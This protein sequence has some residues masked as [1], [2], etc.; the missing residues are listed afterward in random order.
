MNKYAL[1]LFLAIVMIA[2]TISISFSEAL[3][4]ED[5]PE[6][7][8][9]PSHVRVI[10]G[11]NII[12]YARPLYTS[13]DDPDSHLVL[14][15]DSHDGVARL[16]L[17]RTDFKVGCSGTL[18]SDGLHIIT[19]AH[20]VTDKNGI[21]ILKSGSG[22]SATFEGT[23]NGN[24]ESIKITIDPDPSKSK[25]HPDYDGD[26]IKGNDIAVLELLSTAPPQI[27]RIPHANAASV[28]AVNSLVDKNGY[29]HS[30]LFI[31]GADEDT[32]P[33]G[34][35]REGQNKYDAFA[36]I[37]YLEL[38]LTSGDDF[39]FEAIYQYDSDDSNSSHD[40][41]GFF[42]DID[43][44]S[45]VNEVISAPGDSGGPTI[46]EG[47]L[48]GVTSYGITLEFR[49]GPPP[50]TSDCTTN[51]RGV[52]LD[53]SCGE[54]AGDTRVSYYA[55]FINDAL[56]LLEDPSNTS[57]VAVDDDTVSTDED[58]A[59][60]ITLKGTD[61]DGDDITLFTIAS[62][63]TSGSLGAIGNIM[64]D[65]NI[66]SSCTADV[67]YTP[68]LNFNGADSFTFTVKDATL[69]SAAA[70]V[71]INVIDIND[72]PVAVDDADTVLKG[73]STVTD[74]TAN[75]TDV[76]GT[77]NDA[78]I[79]II[80]LP[81]H[82]TLTDNK[83]GT[84]T[85]DHKGLDTTSDFYEYTVDDNDSATSKT[86]TVAIMVNEPSAEVI[87][88]SISPDPLERCSCTK[89]MTILGS[90]FDP[91]VSIT[92]TGGGGPAPIVSTIVVVDD[93]KVT[94]KAALKNGGPA[95][96]TWTVTVTNTD[97]GKSDSILLE[98]TKP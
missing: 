78:S 38:G 95:S 17:D 6:V 29:G 85:Y 2:S 10:E 91:D 70:T 49:G 80:T 55:S 20:C 24:F 21:Y 83:D 45:I 68:D 77:I 31:S 82:G 3:L 32:Y 63:P 8:Q 73:G 35:E 93:G 26:F 59:I 34:F 40:A 64:C 37:M 36:D 47:E 39:N 96:S 23:F 56:G 84:I 27:L 30:G 97:N 62:G 61:V 75:D 87:V 7:S 88:D 67:T 48:V 79:V 86:A 12:A 16:I 72:D 13:L 43:D 9:A 89:D 71:D 18:A 66:P 42:F 69:T 44:T 41:F 76:D 98:I 50:R 11:E 58:T 60:G 46:L 54:F 25:A 52:I 74:V 94:F 53:S 28:S 51:V 65:E 5:L 1:V 92:I 81:T 14:S 33:F 15:S 19:A 22:S 57:P 90:G 4:P